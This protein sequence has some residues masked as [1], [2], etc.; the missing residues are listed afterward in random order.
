MFAT[1]P[2]D[3]LST[4]NLWMTFCVAII[5]TLA[6]GALFSIW[7]RVLI[8]EDAPL[9]ILSFEFM[10]NQAGVERVMGPWSDTVRRAMLYINLVDF[11]Y[12]ITY[13]TT[14][15]TAALLIRRKAGAL[16]LKQLAKL[17]IMVAWFAWFAAG[18]DVIENLVGFPILLGHAAMPW[19]AIMGMAAG[20]KFLILLD[21]LLYIVFISFFL[22]VIGMKKQ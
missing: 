6:L 14:L 10:W 19:A 8:H 22:L 13:S 16:G 21:I 4:H 3:R 1:H 11:I 5:G 20:I 2:F 15:A 9:G 17:G 18:F 7:G 12:M